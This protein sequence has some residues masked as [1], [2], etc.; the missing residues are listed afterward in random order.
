M[1]PE[2]KQYQVLVGE[3]PFQIETGILAEQAGGAVTVQLGNSVVFSAATMSEEP[4]EGINFFPLTVNFEARM[5][6][7]GT[8]PGSFF[9]R[10]GR[11]GEI[12][13]LTARLTDRPIRPLFPD[14]MRN[15]VQVILYSLSADGEQPLDVLS[16]NAASASLMISDVPWN[17]PIAAV[18]VGRIDGELLLNPSYAQIEESDLDLVMAGSREAVLMV[19]S[20]SKEVTEET[21]VEALDYGQLALQPL[22]DLQERMAAEV[23]KP[24]REYTSFAVSED[25]KSR[26]EERA[27]R[28][29]PEILS[30]EYEKMELNESIGNLKEE[31]TEEIAGEDEALLSD[32]KDAFEDVYKKA[33]RQRILE[34]GKRPDGRGYKDVRDVW[35]EVNNS[36]RAH[37]SAIFTRGQTQVMTLTTLG[38]PRDA[39]LIDNLTPTETKRYMHHYNFPPFSVGEVRF[40]RGASRREIGHGVLA[41]RALLPVIPPED[42]FPYTLRLVS[43]V[44]SSNGSS[45]M[46]SVCGSTLSLMDTGVPI[47]APVA[48][49]AMGLVKEGDRYAVLT[50]IQGLEDH[51]GDMDFKVAGTRKGITALQMDIKTSGLSSEIMKEALA[52]AKEARDQIM[53]VM[54]SVISEPREELK[55]YVPRMQTLKIP[56]DKIGAVI[57]PSGETI[58]AIQE[59]TGAKID[60]ED[61]GTVFISTTDEE[62]ARLARERVELLTATPE[63]GRI[64]TGKV[65]GVKDYGAFV[66]I[67]PGTDGLVHISQLESRHVKSV[68]DVVEYGDEITVMVTDITDDGK[69]RLS[70]QAVLEGW[71]L[72]EA[73]KNDRKT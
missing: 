65:V 46:A 4:R 9:R 57:G 30:R 21:I 13:T 27:S 72:E 35:C 1:I 48:G 17:G 7:G 33:V 51:L 47:K 14:D 45:S 56:P 5:Y 8:I 6:A 66:E 23:G 11:P 38:T 34:M 22:I 50:D 70:R 42:E 39:Q 31:I 71:T 20:F 41:E 49:V 12:A 10:E 59:E 69:I 43:E 64:Y 63:V 19:E 55:E 25:I 18:R 52:Q 40:L 68:Q 53:D 3:K 16:V 37:G 32:A 73:R 2:K 61:D 60:I 15:A 26:V 24:K 36:P 28:D 29:I 58:R 62:S 44:L 67:L 54:M